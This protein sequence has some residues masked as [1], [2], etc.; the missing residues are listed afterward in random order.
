MEQNEIKQNKDHVCPAGDH[1]CSCAGC[2]SMC[3][4]SGGAHR[5]WKRHL[6]V[7]AIGVILAFF[8]GMKLGEIKGYMMGSYGMMSKYHGARMDS[9]DWRGDPSMMPAPTTLPP[10]AQ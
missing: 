1:C 4:R 9:L 3:V 10:T 2:G 8:V 7:L 6:I 5:Y